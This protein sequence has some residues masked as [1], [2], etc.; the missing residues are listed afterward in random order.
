MNDYIFPIT[1]T[2]YVPTHNNV[3]HCVS[4]R[5]NNIQNFFY[6]K[7]VQR[8]ELPTL[9]TFIKAQRRR[10]NLATKTFEKR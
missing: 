8:S 6:Y 9:Q 7:I 3:F 10:A 4:N 2:K 1:Y 5:S